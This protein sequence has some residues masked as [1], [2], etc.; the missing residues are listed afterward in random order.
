[1][2]RIF[3]GRPAER[4]LFCRREYHFIF[5]MVPHSIP[6]HQIVL[7]LF[8]LVIID[9]KIIEYDFRAAQRQLYSKFQIFVVIRLRISYICT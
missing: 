4:L 7:H 1:M 3:Y 5:V 2:R 6:F 8:I 9:I